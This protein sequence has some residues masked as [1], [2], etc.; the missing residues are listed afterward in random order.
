MLIIARLAL[1]KAGVRQL[2]IG[3]LIGAASVYN[4]QWLTIE[5]LNSALAKEVHLLNVLSFFFPSSR[6]HCGCA[7]F[8]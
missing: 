4:V 6:G 2:Q 8:S 5:M 1:S 3:L 7:N